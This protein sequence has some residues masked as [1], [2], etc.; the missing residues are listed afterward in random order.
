MKG[1][2]ARLALDSRTAGQTSDHQ[3]DV[4]SPRVPKPHGPSAQR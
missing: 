2:M 1:V 3:A 4:A